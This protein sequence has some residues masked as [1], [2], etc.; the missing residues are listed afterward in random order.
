MGGG[1]GGGPPDRE[2]FFASRDADGNGKLEGNEISER[3][4]ARLAE[5]DTDA[6]GAISKEEFLAAPRPAGN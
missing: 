1:G 5:L 2:A 3:M 4:Q 6:D